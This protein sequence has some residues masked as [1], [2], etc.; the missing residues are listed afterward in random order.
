MIK[1]LLR[2]FFCFFFIFSLCDNLKA[3]DPNV[4]FLPITA[5][6]GLSQNTVVSIL[7]DSRGFMWFGTWNGLNRFDGYNFV[8]YNSNPGKES[9]TDNFINAICEDKNGDLWIGGKHG[10]NRLDYNQNTIT[11]YLHDPSDPNTISQNWIKSILCDS[12][13]R[14]WI[15]TNSNGLN[16][17]QIDPGDPG[18][19]T[20]TR[21]GMQPNQAGQLPDNHINC[22]YEDR[23]GNIWVGTNNGLAKA[24]A[25]FSKV[26]V[27]YNDEADLN[28]LSYPIVSSVY[29]DRQGNIWVGTQ[30][31]LNRLD[32]ATGHFS[33][34]YFDPYN[35]ESLSHHVITDIAEDPEGN[36][37]IGT[38]GGLNMYN[39]STDNFK[40]FP[41]NKDNIYSLNNGF[42]NTLY[43]DNQGN[44]WIGTD[45]GGVSRYNIYQKP[46]EYFIHQPN[47]LNSLSH[48]TVNSLLD[49]PGTLWIGTAGGGLNRYDKARN[50]FT[51]Y[52]NIP[53][54]SHGLNND[55]I[56]ALHRDKNQTLWVGT[57][58]GG[59][60]KLQSLHGNGTFKK[61]FPLEDDDNSLCNVYVSSIFEDENGF[62]LIGTLG[63]LD[64][65]LPDQE[66]FIHIAADPESSKRITEVGCILKDKAGDYWIG[67]RLG[68]FHIN[69]AKLGP[70]LTDEDLTHFVHI[71]GD[72]SSLPGNY[73]ISLHE[74]RSGSLWVG[75][76]GSG[77][78]KID[79]DADGSINFTQFT[80]KDGL[81]NNVIYSILEDEKENLWLS[82]DKG[83]SRFDTQKLEFTNYY[84][85]DGLQTN[86]FYWSAAYKNSDG[87][88]FFG[89]M[90]GVNYFHPD[91][92][93]DITHVPRV[94][95]TD[96]KIFN[97]SVKTGVWNDDRV[98]LKKAIHETNEVRLSYRENI[99]SIEFSALSYY[100]PEKIR[101]AYKLEG[102]DK[103]WVDVSSSR[104]FAGYTNLQG[105]EY[106]FKVKA[107]NSDGV[108]N[109][110]PTTLKIII[111]PPFW[112]TA[113]FKILLVA[114]FGLLFLSFITI[115]TRNL[116]MQ[117]RRLEALVQERTAEIQVQKERL[118]VQAKQLTETNKQLANRQGLIEGQKAQLEVKNKEILDQRDKLIELNKRVQ[119][120]NQLKLRFFTNISHEFRTPIT[121]ILGPIQQL[122]S[123]W[124]GDKESLSTLQMINRNAQRLLH[125]INQ[126]MDFRKIETGK[127][128]LKVSKGHAAGFLEGLYTQFTQ[129]AV[130]RRIEYSFS[131]EKIEAEQWFDH[132]KV[133][134]IVFNLLSNAF[135]F[136][137]EHGEITLS[138]S[139]SVPKETDGAYLII[140]VA[141]TGIGIPRER[142]SY[143]FKR[144]YQ[145]EGSEKN[146]LVGS[147][148][149]LSLT[150]EL[151]KAHHGQISVESEPG[152]GSV[153]TVQ[154]PC[155]KNQYTEKERVDEPSRSRSSLSGQLLN[156]AEVLSAEQPHINGS[157]S[158]KEMNGTKNE[159][160]TILVAE[161]NYDLRTFI[162]VYLSKNYRIIETENGREAY[163]K[164]LLHNPQLII[165]DIMMPEMDGLELCSRIKKNL[166][167]SHIPVILL[168]AR[169]TVENWV[170][171]L[172]TGAD[173]YMPK[174]FNVAIL[175][176]RIK[177]IIERQDN[178]KKLFRRDNKIEVAELTSTSV[179]E[180][181][182]TKAIKVVE[183]HYPDPEFGVENFVEKM[184]VSRSLLHKKLTA[185][186]DQSASNF[187]TTIRLKKSI[188]LLKAKSGNISEVAYEVGFSDP[189][190]FSRT[191]KKFFGVSPREFVQIGLEN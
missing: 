62:L 40:R 153:F 41:Y 52:R 161:D 25:D 75:T 7:Q 143:I 114:V 171:G 152:K 4:R 103:E 51:A 61:Y 24:S 39:P 81:S 108:W 64:L 123:S 134:N 10:L 159:K 180:Q 128:A 174:P 115:R 63:G 47:N 99:F 23:H 45:K 183:E 72:R 3:L 185:L 35:T 32:T 14:I 190:Y 125:L 173:D 157:G 120:V 57:W 169:S 85:T 136:T 11:R 155:T 5:D 84:V 126:L 181:F 59:L 54:D 79:Y 89:G 21:Y 118:E 188:Q 48:N 131:A 90:K 82:T 86:Q 139:Y 88:M 96:L 87:T 30:Y 172:E 16:C 150:K 138:V 165:S 53:Q 177:N 46:F 162:S 184:A 44:V 137:P 156:L 56:S 112:A 182:L 130:Q 98:I 101:Y 166:L 93:K 91:S 104:R 34:F 95:I 68:L 26:E 69:G 38:L 29:E 76:Y 6:D 65:F 2:L 147:G 140:N 15:G 60:H 42:V 66:K 109:E 158:D 20:V 17:L 178:L 170:E 94:A 92:I 110:Q 116:R 168:T 80:E 77:L 175:E 18:Q 151:V 107:S 19:I 8:F 164:V 22:I 176:A 13:G 133:E 149:G 111:T 100:L 37:L 135:K 106:T 146:K 160:P 163:E 58:G 124:K 97:N 132:E 74:D 189:K 122:I 105:G 55:F 67:S 1:R 83:L 43:T 144:F 49:E 28:T 119:L 179:D 113:P 78:S 36:I 71:P 187:I 33:R 50:K 191:F 27:F 186:T 12:Q 117:K 129:L 145:V 31:G 73:V 148:I 9:L 127:L 121:L 141:D 154:L 102:V 70:G 167:T 142:Q